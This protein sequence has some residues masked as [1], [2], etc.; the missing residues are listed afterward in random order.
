[1]LVSILPVPESWS[2][3]SVVLMLR[4]IKSTQKF[5][6]S[7]R[8]VCHNVKSDQFQLR[9]EVLCSHQ[10]HLC[11]TGPEPTSDLKLL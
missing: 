7:K 10:V 11:E 2:V 6:L 5:Y 8:S 1:M 3:F 9:S 4:T